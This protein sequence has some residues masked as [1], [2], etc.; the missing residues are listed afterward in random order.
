MNPLLIVDDYK[1]F[2]DSFMIPGTTKISSN[3]TPRASRNKDFKHVVFFGMQYFIKEYLLDKF[4][5]DFFQKNQNEVVE[6][7]SSVS[8]VNEKN[9]RDL[10]NLRYLPISIKTLDE[11]TLVPMGVPVLTIENTHP[12]FYW[13]TNYLETLISTVLWL[14]STSAT[15]AYELKKLA[16][17]YWLETT[18]DTSFVEWQMHDFST[19]GM[20]SPESGLTSS[21]G[22]L[23][24]FN[25]TDS[26]YSR[27]GIKKYY[28]DKVP[29]LRIRAS[30]HSCMSSG[31]AI[32]G[33]ELEY[34][35]YIINKHNTGI[36][37]LVSDTYDYWN[38]LTKIFPALKEDILNRQPD[39]Y[40]LAK[41]CP[42]GDSGDPVKMICGD[43]EAPIGSP[44]NK[45][46][47]E[48]LWETFSGTIVN[49][50]KVLHERVNTVWGDALTYERIVNI[51]E[52]LKAKKFAPTLPLGIG[53][54]NYQLKT[55]DEFYWAIKNTNTIH[56]GT[57][58]EVYKDPKTDSGKKK[59]LKGLL[60]VGEKDGEL[61][62]EDQVS[63][64]KEKTGLL[65]TVF[66]NGKITK[67]TSLSEIRS[68]L[69][70]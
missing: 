2:H 37:A 12:D 56:N 65:T 53:S 34:Y 29:L 22:H 8:F 54:F 50:Y 69:N 52:G 60:Y 18:G 51:F 15:T 10:H 20:S 45:G 61:Y 43:P 4:N 68:R 7:L 33:S 64:E 23:T 57:S 41:V 39:E 42:R 17:K 19:R 16:T 48:L 1:I 40:G 58:Y 27:H 30:E 67:E 70:G 46:T 28:N 63:A 59:S 44:E 55:R 9:I 32:L 13:L 14:P 26:V 6:E 66:L 38:V 25:A 47:Y 3:L 24:S 21:M 35:R 31:T 11:G 36:L 62:V 5:T 49:G